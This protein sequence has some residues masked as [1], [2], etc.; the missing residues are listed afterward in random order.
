[1]FKLKCS[2]KTKKIKFGN[3]NQI[4]KALAFDCHTLALQ[5]TSAHILEF[6]SSKHYCEIILK[7]P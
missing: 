3:I 2:R 1:M 7:T 4:E 6:R 5:K